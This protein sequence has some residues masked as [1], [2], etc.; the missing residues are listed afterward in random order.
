MRNYND[1]SAEEHS[2]DDTEGKIKDLMP[3][4]IK[5]RQKTVELC[6]ERP[7]SWN[8]PQ[9]NASILTKNAGKPGRKLWLL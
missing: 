2:E 6:R 7:N 9:K 3:N 1:I 4:L 5:I 8:E